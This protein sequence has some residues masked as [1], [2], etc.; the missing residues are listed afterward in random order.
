MATIQLTELT[1][2][3]QD[4]LT[5][6]ESFLSEISD[7]ELGGV[8]GAISPTIVPTII[9]VGQSAAASAAITGASMGIYYGTKA[10]KWW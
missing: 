1:V 3:G 8:N 6:R 10:L 5:D 9:A 7:D 2:T 4:L